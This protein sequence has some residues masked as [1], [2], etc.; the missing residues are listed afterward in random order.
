MLQYAPAILQGVGT[1]ASYFGR[2]KMPSFTSSAQAKQLAQIGKEGVYSPTA[3]AGMLSRQ[4][5]LLGNQANQR[6]TSLRGWLESQGMGQSIAGQSLLDSVRAG[7]TKAIADYS[8]DI[9]TENE[10]SKVNALRERAQLAD[11]HRMSKYGYNADARNQL[12]GGT[13]N[14]LGSAV[15]AYAATRLP[16]GL[17]IPSLSGM[18]DSQL[19][20]WAHDNGIPFED[21]EYLWLSQQEAALGGNRYLQNSVV[22]PRMK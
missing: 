1:L 16:Q 15:G 13:M 8:R 17:Q 14:A 20:K 9:D 11:Q 12:I 18:D 4:A 21:A 10:L 19:Y 5:G 22:P 2:K 3:R 7:S 6:T